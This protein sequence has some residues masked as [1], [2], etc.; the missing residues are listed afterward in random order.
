MKIQQR[1]LHKPTRVV[2]RQLGWQEPEGPVTQEAETVA[3]ARMLKISTGN[4]E[5]PWIKTK[6]N[7]KWTKW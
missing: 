2:R 4:T 6:S 5:K 7:K 3:C 1:K